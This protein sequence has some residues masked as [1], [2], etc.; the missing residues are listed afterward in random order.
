M[1]DPSLVGVA[2]WQQAFA[3]APGVNPAGALLSDSMRGRIGKSH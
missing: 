2:F 1:N 3:L